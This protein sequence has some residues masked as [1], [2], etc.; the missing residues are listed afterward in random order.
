ME[1]PKSLDQ[2]GI[3]RKANCQKHRDADSNIGISQFK[4]WLNNKNNFHI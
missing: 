1:L 2:N 3:L 4:C